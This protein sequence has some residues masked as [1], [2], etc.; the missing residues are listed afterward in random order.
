MDRI[1]IVIPVEYRH[2]I[3]ILWSI[4]N[5]LFDISMSKI[6]HVLEETG[7]NIFQSFFFLHNLIELTMV[8]PKPDKQIKDI[9]VVTVLFAGNQVN[10]GF[11]SEKDMLR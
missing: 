1:F 11:V 2:R 5:D 10:C 9:D 4:D 8:L 6:T 7:S 3:I